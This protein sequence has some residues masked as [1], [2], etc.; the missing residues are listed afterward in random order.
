M[1]VQPTGEQDVRDNLVGLQNIG[2]IRTM[3]AAG[4]RLAFWLVISRGVLDERTHLL[5][6][7]ATQCSKKL[8]CRPDRKTKAPPHALNRLIE[9]N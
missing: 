5:A 1:S 3:K 2:A 6:V 9:G 7:A 4:P 8:G